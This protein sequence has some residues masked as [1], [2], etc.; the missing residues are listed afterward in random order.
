MLLFGYMR[1]RQNRKFP[2][3]RSG[4]RR[5]RGSG[6]GREKRSVN[7]AKSIRTSGGGN[8]WCA[9]IKFAQ[10]G[11]WS[12]PYDFWNA[13]ADRSSTDERH[14]HIVGWS[15]HLKRSNGGEATAN[16]KLWYEWKANKSMVVVDGENTG[17]VVCGQESKKRT[18]FK[19]AL[20]KIDWN[21]LQTTLLLQTWTGSRGEQKSWPLCIWSRTS[22]KVANRAW[23]VTE[24]C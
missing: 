10:K 3:R 19:Q 5:R 24:H 20:I 12:K 8:F 22:A 18:R 2:P 16:I 4:R 23:W 17:L 1:W 21:C 11:R 7:K 15:L 13:I 6:S 14:P 9:E